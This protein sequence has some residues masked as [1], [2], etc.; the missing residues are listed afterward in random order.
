M[1]KITALIL[2]ALLLTG[3]STS[4]EKTDNKPFPTLDPKQEPAE[5]MT[6]PEKVGQLFMVRCDSVTPEEI[7]DNKPGAI[8]MFAS[9]FADL[10]KNQVKEKISSF[11]DSLRIEPFIAVD[12]EGGT[13]VRVSQNPKLVPEKY[14]SPQGYYKEGG[15]ELVADNAREKSELLLSLGV[16]MNL[17]PVADVSEN[18]EDFIYDRSFGKDAQTTADYV[19]KV[20][21]VMDECNM[22]SC[23]K[24]FPGYGGNVDT[25]TT[26]AI[27]TRPLSALQNNDFLP[28]KSGI[29]A[30]ADA[31]LVSH[32]IIN[33]IDPSLPATLSKPVHDIL[34]DELG[35]HGLIITDDMSM[36]AASDYTEP[37]KKAVL[38]GNDLIIVTD[39]ATAYNEV[40]SAVESGEIPIEIID[41]A[42]NRIIKSK[43]ARGIY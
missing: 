19:S 22:A 30:G 23:L 13:V 17:A 15:M 9:D 35:F 34:R 42:V 11:K 18:P 7:A 40:L 10:D 1:K 3:C 33:D 2:S 26:V 31:V 5:S 8:I 20:V 29:A 37:Y 41:A 38:A 21:S 12:E 36:A 43:Q 27:D 4:V 24:H 32:N 14:K 25:H 6:L 28:F 16:T 39:F